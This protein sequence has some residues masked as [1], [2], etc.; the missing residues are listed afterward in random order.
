MLVAGSDLRIPAGALR[1]R[2]GEDGKLE[3][4]AII[5]L[6]R[7]D[8]WP[9]WL[10]DMVESAAEAKR[11]Y[12]SVAAVVAD[13]NDEGKARVLLA[14][15]RASMR[16]ITGAAF[17]FDSLYAAVKARAGA[18]PHEATWHAKRTARPAQIHATLLHHL[19]SGTNVWSHDFVRFLRQLFH[20][21]G[22]A[23]RPGS[24]FR[25]AVYRPEFDSGVDWHFMLFRAENAVTVAGGTITA[26]D[27]LIHRGV[28]RDPQVL[29]WQPVAARALAKVAAHYRAFDLPP[30]VLNGDMRNT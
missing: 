28:S 25:K 1:I 12:G 16:A 11:E 2:V 6:L 7:T 18:H 19:G 22:A 8:M 4:P 27:S 26:F 13:N 21:R 5:P 24:E 9:T 29:E 17:A 30:L 23:V 3:S 10:M 20:A 14:E 15:L